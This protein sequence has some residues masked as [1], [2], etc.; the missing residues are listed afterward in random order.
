MASSDAS[1]RVLITHRQRF[2]TNQNQDE[3]PLAGNLGAEADPLVLAGS[4]LPPSTLL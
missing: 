2:L 4:S 1:Q 3:R